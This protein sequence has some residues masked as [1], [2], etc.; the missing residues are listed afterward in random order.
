MLIENEDM[1][2]KLE[3]QKELELS[4]EK[5]NLLLNELN[6]LKEYNKDLLYQIDDLKDEIS[7][8]EADNY[9]LDPV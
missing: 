4:E 8:L 1:F 6:T 3:L 5:V 2:Q 7:A 9:Y